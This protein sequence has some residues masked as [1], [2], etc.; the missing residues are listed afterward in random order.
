[1]KKQS[2][3]TLIELIMVIVILGILGAVVAPKY[4]DL[5]SDAASAAATATAGALGAASTNNY[6]ACQ[7]NTAKCTTLVTGASTKCSSIG[8]LMSPAVTFTV[9]AL[10]ATTTAGTLYIVTD[11]ALTT[12]GVTC[13]FVY[14]DGTAAGQS[15]TFVGFATS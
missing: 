6:A 15:K 3:F 7:V 10:P 1:M 14:G 8:T 12:S 2:G 4:I 9:G 13:T 5:K 11:S